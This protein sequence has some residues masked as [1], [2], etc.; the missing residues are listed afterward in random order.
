MSGWRAFLA[1][2]LTPVV[3]EALRPAL[4]SLSQVSAV[5]SSPPDGIHLTLHFLGS[6]D[7]SRLDELAGHAAPVAALVPPF[8]V[9]VRGVGAF[10]ARRR[11]QV[12]YAGF[13]QP[14]GTPL[15]TLH[16]RMGSVIAALGLPVESRPFKPHLTL[17]RSRRPLRREEITVVEAWYRHWAET[18]FG[19]LEI[20]EVA[21]MRSQIGSGPPRYTRLHRLPLGKET[22]ARRI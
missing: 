22:A 19:P 4:E 15:H 12:F 8:E 11:P 20:G 3:M 18:S 1:V 7:P 14:Q 10:P 2:E 5:R 13:E 6:V 17:G 16:G 9:E 21:L